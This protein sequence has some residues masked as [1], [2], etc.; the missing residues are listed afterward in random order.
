M[1]EPVDLD[2]YDEEDSSHK[3]ELT[4]SHIPFSKKSKRLRG[5]SSVINGTF[6]DTTNC[7]KKVPYLKSVDDEKDWKH[8]ANQMGCDSAQVEI[9]MK[10]IQEQLKKKD[11]KPI[12]EEKGKKI[13]RRG[14]KII[15][16]T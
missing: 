1:E 15:Q 11:L 16:R 9:M 10:N 6:T 2:E 12:T 8:M 7:G 14:F 5:S 13:K 4:R 3:T